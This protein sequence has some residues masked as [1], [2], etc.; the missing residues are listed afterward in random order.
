MSAASGERDKRKAERRVTVAEQ[1]GSAY[2]NPGLGWRE[3]RRKA[4]R[5]G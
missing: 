1:H 5:R 2:L 4:E 3:D